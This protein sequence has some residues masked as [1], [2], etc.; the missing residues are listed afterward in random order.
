VT[1]RGDGD[2]NGRRLR[3]EAAA[4]A[5]ILEVV[6]TAHRN[7]AKLTEEAPELSRYVAFVAGGG[8]PRAEYP[9][10]GAALDGTNVISTSA[11]RYDDG[12]PVATC[13]LSG[14]VDDASWRLEWVDLDGKTVTE[15]RCRSLGGIW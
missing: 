1:L 13:R 5:L 15:S 6:A 4:K 11:C 7:S 3:A 10:D 12:Y 9:H 8:H 2:V 14:A